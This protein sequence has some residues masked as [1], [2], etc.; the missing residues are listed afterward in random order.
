MIIWGWRKTRKILLKVDEQECSNCHNTNQ[1]DLVRLTSW[2]T[3]FFIP[4]IPYKRE[5]FIAC[6][7]CEFGHKIDK[8]E[9]ERIMLLK[10]DGSI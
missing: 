2:F 8:Y 10:G 4:I 5:Y 3:L 7:I 9:K 1:F 6:P